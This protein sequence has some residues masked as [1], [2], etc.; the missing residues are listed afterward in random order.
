[1]SAYETRIYIAVLTGVLVLAIV[2]AFFMMTIIRYQRRKVASHQRRLRTETILLEKDRARI[3]ADLHDDLGA[4]LSAVKLKLQCLSTT[5]PGDLLL[6]NQS[7]TLIDNTMQRLRQ[8]SFNLMPKLLQQKGLQDTLDELVDII[9]HSSSMVIRYTCSMEV[10]DE[11]KAIHIYRVAQEIMNN[12]LKHS[13]ASEVDFTLAQT[14]DTIRLHVKD[15]G[16]GFDKNKVTDHPGLGLQ[17]I[18]ARADLLGAKVYLTTSEGNGTDYL[19][20]IPA[21]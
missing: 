11:E 3:A 5:D 4:S 20:D 2:I 9:A 19:I 1:M 7:D 15:N 12:I 13:G 6:L 16:T 14:G 21:K 18:M 8:I 17:N 10:T